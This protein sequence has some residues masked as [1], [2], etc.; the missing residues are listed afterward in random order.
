MFFLEEGWAGIC[1]HGGI[2]RSLHGCLATRLQIIWMPFC[3]AIWWP[4]TLSKLRT[5][6][7]ADPRVMLLC[8][9]W[10]IVASRMLYMGMSQNGSAPSSY[11]FWGTQ[12]WH[13]YSETFPY[14]KP[15]SSWFRS[16]CGHS[17][18][19][20][21]LKNVAGLLLV[22]CLGFLLV[23]CLGLLVHHLGLLLWIWVSWLLFFSSSGLRAI[24]LPKHHLAM[25]VLQHPVQFQLVKLWFW[26]WKRMFLLGLFGCPH[27]AAVFITLSMPLRTP[28]PAF[29]EPPP[30]F[31]SRQLAYNLC[32]GLLVHFL[33]VLFNH[34]FC[35]RPIGKSGYPRKAPPVLKPMVF[36][37]NPECLGKTLASER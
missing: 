4:N 32:L 21:T 15:H 36:T 16:R 37:G 2:C 13:P 14:F 20:Q 9:I 3:G 26:A 6:G 1:Q 8:C 27:V 7:Q 28:V 5:P 35:S 12:F 24:L 22:W 33:H 29:K 18:L 34:F 31:T 25:E 23:W 11:A 17:F 30:E 10:C 19:F